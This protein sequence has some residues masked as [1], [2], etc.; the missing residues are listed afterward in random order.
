MSIYT[1]SKNTQID[2]VISLLKK[3]GIKTPD[4]PDPTTLPGAATTSMDVINALR[5]SKA[6]DP[7]R[8]PEVQSVFIAHQIASTGGL[9][10]TDQEHQ[11]AQR[12]QILIKHQTALK[13]QIHRRFSDLAQIIASHAPA[14]AGVEDLRTVTVGGDDPAKA[15]AA[16]DTQVAIAEIQAV[17][18]ASGPVNNLGR[19]TLSIGEQLGVFVYAAPDVDHREL[20]H[21][22][23]GESI[24]NMARHGIALELARD[25][26]D[27]HARHRAW[28][29]EIARRRALEERARR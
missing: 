22:T 26:E 18:A 20:L 3:A 25:T 7:Y 28:Q 8:D 9:Y 6:K 27:I 15:R 16:L 10:Y 23:G 1:D 5:A 2:V 19:P 13:K 29:Q 11:A 17:I 14:L 12:M 4:L 24:W 21:E